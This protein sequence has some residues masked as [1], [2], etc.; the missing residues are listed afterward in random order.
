MTK[1]PIAFQKKNFSHEATPRGHEGFNAG[2]I[3]LREI[4][5]F[6]RGKT[7]S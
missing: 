5:V 1:S 4:F 6:L 2:I 7:F 3:P